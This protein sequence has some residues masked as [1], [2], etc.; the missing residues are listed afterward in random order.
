MLSRI[1]PARF[2]NVSA[3][4]PGGVFTLVRW[5]GY[6]GM[7]EWVHGWWY[8]WMDG[9]TQGWMDE[10]RDGRGDGWMSGWMDGVDG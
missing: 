3:Y 10:W 4:V 1:L 6:E 9:W 7:D 8:G 5:G 2:P